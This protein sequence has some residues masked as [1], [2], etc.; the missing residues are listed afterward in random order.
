M[1]KESKGKLRIADEEARQRAEKEAVVNVAKK[2]LLWR[3]ICDNLAPLV[4]RSRTEQSLRRIGLDW[5][6]REWLLLQ[7]LTVFIQ[8]L[9]IRLVWPASSIPFEGKRVLAHW[10]Q[11]LESLYYMI[12]YGSFGPRMSAPIRHALLRYLVVWT[13]G[14]YDEHFSVFI[15]E[16]LTAF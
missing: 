9:A 8:S 12:H 16:Y 15:S 4:Q 7:P 5:F 11:I 1:E 13:I 14:V 2:L 3:R 10:I 6:T